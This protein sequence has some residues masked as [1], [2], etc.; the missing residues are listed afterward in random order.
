MQFLKCFQQTKI[1]I[2]SSF[3]PQ[4]N[5]VLYSLFTFTVDIIVSETLVA[6][7]NHTLELDI[8]YQHSCGPGYLIISVIESVSLILSKEDLSSGS[9]LNNM[10]PKI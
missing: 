8:N 4:R 5:S 9:V 3:I 7:T 1:A 6:G 10:C 2:L